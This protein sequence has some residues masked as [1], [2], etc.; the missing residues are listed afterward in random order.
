MTE[1]FEWYH[2]EIKAKEEEI[3][4]LQRMMVNSADVS[5]YWKIY[6]DIEKLKMEKWTLEQM[7]EEK[8]IYIV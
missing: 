2:R 5:E 1:E 4:R 7:A 8:G 3:S 6:G